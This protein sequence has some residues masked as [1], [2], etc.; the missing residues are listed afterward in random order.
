MINTYGYNTFIISADWD[1]G[2]VLSATGREIYEAALNGVTVS[3]M[4]IPE[5]GELGEAEIGSLAGPSV[6]GLI[7]TVDTDSDTKA[8]MYVFVFFNGGQGTGYACTSLDDYP[9]FT[10]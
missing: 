6:L 1:N 8:D 9:V 7:N 3:I 4:T 10:E 2:G 5:F